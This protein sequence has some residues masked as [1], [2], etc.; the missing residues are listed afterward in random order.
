M[1]RDVHRRIIEDDDGPPC[2][3][4]ASQNITATTT[5]LRGISKHGTP[6]ECQIQRNIRA[7]LNQAVE[8]QAESSMSR[9]RGLNVSQRMTTVQH[10]KDALVHQTPHDGGKHATTPVWG[11]LSHNHD[12]RDTVNA[13]RCGQE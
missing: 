5:L 8:Q 6:E 7:L 9:R 12:M 3:P 2:F 11:C 4:P 10:G 13:R 1:A